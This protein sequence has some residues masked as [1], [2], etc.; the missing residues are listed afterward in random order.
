MIYIYAL[1][2]P[3]TKQIRYIGKSVR[4]KERLTN[5]CNDKSVTWR[6]NWIQSIL[7][8]G[9]RPELLILQTL[10]DNEDW[11]LAESEWIK[12]AREMNWP[13]TNCTDGGDGL[14]NPPEEVRQK[15]IT[16]WTGRKHSEETKILIGQ[17]S[18]GRKHTEEHKEHM[19]QI[20]TGREIAWRD[21][22][23]KP[24]SKPR[25]Q[26]FCGECGRP[27][28]AKGL[29]GLHYQRKHKKLREA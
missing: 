24:K 15:I 20:M 26:V 11:Q 4:P 12:K 29:C 1:V 18:K 9:K 3:F 25:K 16:T 28:K 7:A 22:L 23:S 27:Q 6:T 10:D 13:L 5:H 17:A 14:V 8:K 2:D 21:K 19:R